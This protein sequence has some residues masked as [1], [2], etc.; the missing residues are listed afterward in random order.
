MAKRR[1][2]KRLGIFLGALILLITA[3]VLTFPYW[4]QYA[5]RPAANHL[6][7]QY[8]S[9]AR[10]KDGRFAI[11]DV[12]RT[13]QAFDIKIA[14]VEGY[15]PE[16]WYRKT[17]ET[18]HPAAFVEVNGWHVTLHENGKSAGSASTNSRSVYGEWKRA[19]HY[20]EM[21]RHWAPKATLLNGIL[22]YK[23]KEYTFPVI[24]WDAGKLD[25]GGVW[26]GSAVPF[27]IKGKL[28]GEPPYQL[29][30]AMT[31]LDLRARLQLVET[32]GLLN[33]KLLGIYK[34][35]RADINANFATNGILPLI[36][37]LKAPSLK[38]PAD[39]LKL[40]NYEDL[41][42]SVNGEW[43]TN[44]YTVRFKGH[45]EPIGGA[46]LPPVDLALNASG[47][48]N[49]IQ[50]ENA[51]STAP[52]LQLSIS[53]P[54]E[55]SYRGRLLSERAEIRVDADLEKVPFLKMN[56][57]LKGTIL[58]EKGSK[59]PMASIRAQADNISARGFHAAQARIEG[60][61]DWPKLESFAA[62]IQVQTNALVS[63]RGS[64]DLLARSLGETTISAEGPVG[65]NFLPA[66]VQFSTLKLTAKVSGTA[67][68]LLHSGEAELRQFETAQTPPMQLE[69]A[70]SARQIAFEQLMLRARA[71]PA[72]LFL[73]GSGFIDGSV[74]NFVL[75]DVR[76][77]KGD[78]NYLTLSN[79]SRISLSRGNE[80][81]MRVEVSPLSMTGTNKQLRLSGHLTWPKEG[82]LNVDAQE[83]NP[84]LFQFFVKRSLRG[85]ELAELALAAQ[86]S[87]S[88]LTGRISTDCSIAQEAFKRLGARVEAQLDENGLKLTRMSLRDPS[89]EIGRAE[90]F[91]PLSIRPL[92]AK[93]LQLSA[94]DQ[95]DFEMETATNADFWRTISSLTKVRLT[96]AQVG[97]K[98]HGTTRK[99]TGELHLKADGLALVQTNRPL[100]GISPIEGRLALNE[101]VL[102]LP[103][104]SLRIEDQPVTISGEMELGQNFWTQ[105]R[106]E[107]VK[108][109]L[110]HAHLH[111]EG[112][113][114]QLAPFTTYLPKYLS[115]QGR[116][117][118]NA[119]MKPGRNFDGRVQVRGVET[120]PISKVGVVQ[121][122]RADIS[123]KDREVQI[124][125]L[126]GVLGGER[127]TVSG[128]IDLSP[129]SLAKGYPD[130]NLHIGGKNLPLARNPDVILRSDLDLTVR[131]G[132]NQFPIIVGDATLRDSFLFRDIATL[133]PGRVARP[134]RRPPYFSITQDPVSQWRMRVN[135]RGENFMRVRSPFFQGL[136]SAN[137][138]V[139]G[140]MLEPMALGEAS[141]PSGSI[142]FPFATLEIRQAIVSM[143][144][145]DPY[146]PHVFAVASGRAFGF[147]I[148]MEAEGPADQPIIQFS[149][150]PA[151]TSEQIVLMVTTGQIPRQ[152]FGF[153]TQDRASRLAMFLGKSLWE[154]LHPG[155]AAEEKLT[156]RSGQDV[157]EQG[158]Q[159]YEVEYKLNEKWSLVGEYDRFGAVN[160]NV[161]WKLFSR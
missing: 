43:K 68:N 7:I 21:A 45:A 28:S 14:R 49:S 83:I 144:S 26:P 84:E 110:D 34:E 74:T 141:I 97:L 58:L 113:E 125:D 36:A 67:S 137:F 72:T 75:Q 151:L 40:K 63:V 70:W 114:I 127:M 102:R 11:T 2:L 59:F 148:R 104:L 159:T 129:E 8:S 41:T 149:S 117:G 86:W 119:E 91:L 106:E 153:S 81:A 130:V 64:A 6:G 135:V 157:T 138:V 108:Y 85:L 143:T 27:E 56:G 35:N 4:F 152:D 87:N 50:I 39:L 115:P 78:A 89:G 73:S 47:N 116:L 54:M 31:P 12:V 158:R 9:F 131:N 90:G 161:K 52:G 17:K 99:P 126:S 93:I 123:L 37:T 55:L 160:A 5:L 80:G 79:Q 25:A 146:L 44:S 29:S 16:V 1:G 136:V 98:V 38:I 139:R 142:I 10:L 118:V 65:T 94:R 128:K 60:R 69:L 145:E 53:N 77:S 20:I 88:P 154:K 46:Q 109:T 92:E 33:A 100:P 122:I 66:S 95:I 96:N 155:K 13:N 112:P 23:G 42:G 147:D 111:L 132:T 48:T 134:E 24:T 51:L 124:A 61:L 18:N 82:E 71:G 19:E 150:V 3:V 140:T 133:V 32:N 103:E 22:E 120:R 15:L 76:L 156:I 30:Y 101:Q 121:G 107:I 62:E 57:S 105:R